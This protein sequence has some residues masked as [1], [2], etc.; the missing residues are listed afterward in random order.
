MRTQQTAGAVAPW[1]VGLF[2]AVM[3]LA[4]LSLAWRLAAAQA[5]APRWI[6]DALGALAWVAFLLQL[7][8]QLRRA[9]YA[10][11]AWLA[12]LNHPATQPFAGTFW[13]SV[14]LLPMLLPAA[15]A[16]FARSMWLAG[17]AGMAGF[18]WWSLSRWLSGGHEEAQIGP[19]WLIP[20]VG[21]LD[22]PLAFPMLGFDGLR[23]AMVFATAAGLVLALPL[24]AL[25][26]ARLAL[27]PAS[28]Q[29]ALLIL[30]APFAVGFSAYVA[31]AG[32]V[33]AFARSLFYLAVFLLA[34]LL[35]RVHA[36]VRGGPFEFS[37]WA[38]SFP[39]AATAA[40]AQRYAA[41]WP[42]V[43]GRS[44]ACA[45]LVLATVAIG[46]LLGLS[47]RAFARNR[48]LSPAPAGR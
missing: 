47:L 17:V 16:P 4:G 36:M 10:R 14:L 28:A 20:V 35:P 1:P 32:T 26:F 13:I 11:A 8:A 3:G 44:L 12:E 24:L 6:G 38:L 42:S 29:P 46:S 7:A 41:A 40:A 23:E 37:W 48:V 18:A 27:R 5:A 25:V 45:L 21:L 34:A 22:I 9:H 43:V 30:L 31:V 2:G 33:D 15:L 39:L 19:A